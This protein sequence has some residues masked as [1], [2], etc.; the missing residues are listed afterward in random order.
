M[1]RWRLLNGSRS[2][3][4]TPTWLATFEALH[5]ATTAREL[6]AVLLSWHGIRPSTVWEEPFGLFMRF[7]RHDSADAIV[8]AA[9]LCTD[10]RWRTAS[11]HLVHR[12]GDASVLTARDV[13]TLAEQ[14]LTDTFDVEVVDPPSIAAS[15]GRVPD[16]PPA[17][18]RLPPDLASAAPLGRVAD[19]AASSGALA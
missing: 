14:F 17:V 16:D 4:I 12:I 1:A 10:H 11:H 5:S 7:H 2:T 18:D 19:C 13:E 15:Q 9:L 8:T 3:L 6:W